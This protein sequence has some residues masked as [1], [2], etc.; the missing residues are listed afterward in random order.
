ML[1]G[2]GKKEGRRLG[3]CKGGVNKERN[4]YE[5]QKFQSNSRMEKQPF[6]SGKKKVG[7]REG[8]PLSRK[9]AG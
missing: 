7:L 1:Y 5:G 6:C 8:K 4:L 3:I 2:P 9:G